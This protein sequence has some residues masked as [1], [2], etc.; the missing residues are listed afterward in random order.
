MQADGAAKVTFAMP[1][2]MNGSAAGHT[3][4]TSI[5]IY[6]SSARR[7]LQ[8]QQRQHSLASQTVYRTAAAKYGQ[9][10]AAGSDLADAC[11]CTH[12]FPKNAVVVGV[13]DD[14]VLIL[15][16]AS[17]GPTCLTCNATVQEW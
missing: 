16:G 12:C 9:A 10:A 2:C 4:E 8:H 1:K 14:D 7:Q 17:M 5:D 13:G 15:W 11:W 3:G 6:K